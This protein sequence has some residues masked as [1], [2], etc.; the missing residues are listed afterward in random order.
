M[1]YRYAWELI[2][3]AE[4][5]LGEPLA[6][7]RIGGSHGGGSALTPRGERMVAVFERLNADVAAYADK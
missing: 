4:L 7:R 3:A 5:H 2:R 6:V 1:S